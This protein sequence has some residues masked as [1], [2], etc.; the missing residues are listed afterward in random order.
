LKTLQKSGITPPY[1]DYFACVHILTELLYMQ[2]YICIHQFFPIL[3]K[4][5]K[6]L[7]IIPIKSISLADFD[8]RL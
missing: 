4:S 8:E 6:S 1:T 7:R 3:S 5:A 2:R